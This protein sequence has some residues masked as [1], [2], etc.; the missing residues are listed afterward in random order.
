ME[1]EWDEAKSRA[2]LLLRGFDFAH[3]ALIVEGPVIER[4]DRRKDYRERRLIATPMADGTCLT[5]VY[6]PRDQRYRIQLTPS[7][8]S[9]IMSRVP[10]Y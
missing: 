1:L 7:N 5:V 4:E 9:A 2:D 3:A 6:A 10:S 8:R